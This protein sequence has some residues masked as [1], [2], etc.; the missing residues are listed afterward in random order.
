[1]EVQ[2]FIDEFTSTQA[3]SIFI[4]E[5]V[6][7]V[8]GNPSV[9]FFDES[10]DAKANRYLFRSKTIDTPFLN[11]RAFEYSKTFV[12]PSPEIV[13]VV[14]EIRLP[15]R[16]FPRL[17]KGLFLAQRKISI[18]FY[19]FG[20]DTS[21]MLRLKKIEL[22]PQSP[23]FKKITKTSVT[24]CIYSLYLLV[25]STILIYEYRERVTNEHHG[26]TTFSTSK[27]L[28]IY[29]HRES[30]SADMKSKASNN[31]MD[32]NSLPNDAEVL[33]IKVSDVSLI[34]IFKTKFFL[35]VVFEVLCCLLRLNETPSEMVYRLV[36]IICYCPSNNL[37]RWCHVELF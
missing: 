37:I 36:I 19:G 4:D 15:S 17:R 25:V 10:I 24:S 18:P 13:I 6:S 30:K 2:P 5:R 29:H 31:T 28:E 32:P 27:L 3:F 11:S 16:C 9:L 12:A 20:H 34:F 35:K 7:D 14:S 33:G 21:S 22:S 23:S 1:M 26:C 8:E